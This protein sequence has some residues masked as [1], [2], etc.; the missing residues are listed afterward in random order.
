VGAYAPVVAD[1][2]LRNSLERSLTAVLDQI[3]R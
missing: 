2:C 3:A 1:P